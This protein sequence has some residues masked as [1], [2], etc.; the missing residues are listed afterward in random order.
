M[1][2]AAEEARAS[3]R[4]WPPAIAAL[5][6]EE[7]LRRL[8]KE[9]HFM[10]LLG[11]LVSLSTIL[12]DVLV[13]PEKAEHGAILR[14]LAIAPV[15]MLGL[16]AGSRGWRHILAFCVGASPIA[17]IA[18]LAHFSFLLP[19]EMGVRYLYGGALVL[20]LGNVVLPYSLRGLVIFDVGALFVMALMM[21][22]EGPQALLGNADVL[23][24]GALVAAATLPI[25]ARFEKL[26]QG[27]FLLALRARIIGGELLAA[28]RALHTLSET[29]AL[30]EIANRRH[31]ERVFESRI[32]APGESGTGADLIAIMM[33]DLDH[34]KAFNDTHGHQAGDY[35]LKQVAM[36]LTEL[37]LEAGGIVARYG[38]EEFIA[39]VRM[40]DPEEVLSIAEEA[41]RTI[42]DALVPAHEHG[43]S[44]ITA[45]IGIGMAP[46]CAHLPR[47]ELIE[48]A[49][50]ALYSG[51]AQGRNR[52][53]VV[54]AEAAF[55]DV[56]S[57][58]IR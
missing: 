7:V 48:M 18:V 14:V 20:G 31:F 22:L 46:A 32:V 28:N 1:V 57:Q 23:V 6:N 21:L 50:A 24:V 35:C 11:L 37:F 12:V 47:E 25:A 38:G 42:A 54:Q 41:R 52:V 19:A 49:D 29:D 15:T 26:R 17:F 4:Q 34:F 27:N 8:Y 3:L 2:D 33:I 53:E 51:K 9:Q 13:Q 44:M 30:T 43:R 55:G 56:M 45:T 40:R 10:F 36:A 39:A 16:L 58:R 5:Y